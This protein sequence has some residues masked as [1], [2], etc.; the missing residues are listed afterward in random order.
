[1]STTKSEVRPVALVTGAAGGIGAAV[2]RTLLDAGA[3]VVA[4]DLAGE[5][6]DRL[7]T[8]NSSSSMNLRTEVLDITSESAVEEAVAR[9]ETEVGPIQWGVQ[10]AGVLE[11][12][13]LLETSLESWRRVFEVNATGSF[14]VA[15]TLARTMVSRGK[16][17]IVLVG[18]NAGGVPRMMMGAYAASKAA[19]AHMMRCLALDVAPHGVRCNIVAPGS[20]RTSMQTQFQ[21]GRGDEAIIAGSLDAFRTGIPLGRIAEPEDVAGA[22]AFLLSDAAR[23]ITMVELYVDGGGAL[24]S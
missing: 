24:R 23:H 1:M 20:T 19:A 21:D 18:S 17:S 16:G 5:A 10:V 22:V 11:V 8:E 6:L 7:A 9:V 4:T 15:R 13:S 3:H 14:I 2:V 12:G